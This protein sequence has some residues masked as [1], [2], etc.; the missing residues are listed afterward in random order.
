MKV[1]EL[2]EKLKEYPE[3]TEIFVEWRDSEFGIKHIDDPSIDFKEEVKYNKDEY[4]HL[5][6]ASYLK[7]DWIMNN[8]L[9]IS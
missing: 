2:I 3:D 4:W 9:I 7:W 1:K 8:V 5:T 6:W